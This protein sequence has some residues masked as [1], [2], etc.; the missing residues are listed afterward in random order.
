MMVS[1]PVVGI[2]V[3]CR[4]SKIKIVHTHRHFVFPI[5]EPNNE[6][7]VEQ[8]LQWH[9]LQSHLATDQKHEELVSSLKRQFEQGR[10]EVH[11]VLS[12]Q[13]ENVRVVAPGGGTESAATAATTASTSRRTATKALV[14]WFTFKSHQD[15]MLVK[16]SCTANPNPMHPVLSVDQLGKNSANGGSVWP[17]TVRCQQHGKFEIIGG[18]VYFTDVGST[19]GTT[20]KDQ[21]L[22]TNSPFLLDD[23]V[24][25]ILGGST[26]RVTLS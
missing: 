4:V 7:T 22:A 16:L 19:N 1:R 23:N 6:W 5:A 20:C 24:E 18:K 25:L 15:H 9:L 8:V 14:P 12:E 21:L 11:Q 2:A 26:L 17:R 3:W 10:E 13:S